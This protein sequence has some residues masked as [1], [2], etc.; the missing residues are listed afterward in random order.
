MGGFRTSLIAYDQK[1]RVFRG[2]S[3]VMTLGVNRRGQFL[4]DR[5]M[6][7][8]LRRLPLHLVADLELLCHGGFLEVNHTAAIG[9]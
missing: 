4:Y 1:L 5:A 9:P 3:D 8:A 7:H 2:G 6:Q